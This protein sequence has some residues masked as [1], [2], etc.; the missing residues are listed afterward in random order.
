MQLLYI[1]ELEKVKKLDDF[2]IKQRRGLI[3]TH[4][5]DDELT[6]EDVKEVMKRVSRDSLPLTSK[7]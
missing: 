4:H 7:K 3:V 6:E 1:N 2:Y 5:G